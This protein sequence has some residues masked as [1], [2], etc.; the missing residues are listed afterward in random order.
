MPGMTGKVPRRLRVH[1]S[2][3]DIDGAQ[4]SQE[5]VGFH[6]RILQHECDHLDGMLYPTRILHTNAFGFKD[7]IQLARD[8]GLL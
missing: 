7:E 8:E 6:A 5:A 2:G 3:F 1:Y 4:T